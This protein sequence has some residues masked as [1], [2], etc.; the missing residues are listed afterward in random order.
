MRPFTRRA[1]AQRREWLLHLRTPA[2][3]FLAAQQMLAGTEYHDETLPAAG[4][5]IFTEVNLHCLTLDR[6]EPTSYAGHT[7]Q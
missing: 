1:R 3:L 4:S 2:A 7:L 6:E 5:L